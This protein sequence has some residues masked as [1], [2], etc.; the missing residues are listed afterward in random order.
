MSW[1]S[2][3]IRSNAKKKKERK[4][5]GDGQWQK[6]SRS[7]AINKDKMTCWLLANSLPG[8]TDHFAVRCQDQGSFDLSVNDTLDLMILSYFNPR[9]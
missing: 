7:L 5:R 2:V 8:H 3:P 1:C 4:E 6:E 9:N